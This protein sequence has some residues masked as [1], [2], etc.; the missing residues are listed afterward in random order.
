MNIKLKFGLAV[1]MLLILMSP[2]AGQQG[3]ETS[4]G[5]IQLAFDG[6]NRRAAGV[7]EISLD[8]PML[9]LGIRMLSTSES[10]AQA[11]AMLS[12]LKGVYIKSFRFDGEGKYSDSDLANVRRQLH[13]PGWAHIMSVH[14]RP[15][16]Q[17]VD[18]Y[19]M[20]DGKGVAGMAIIVACPTELRVVN[21]VGPVDPA[22]LSR[23]GG[24]FGIPQV[25]AD[26]GRKDRNRQ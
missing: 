1:P 16:R 11:R 12:R 7:N 26:A 17:D 23:L 18:V 20:S 15:D 24:H 2:L 9:Q 3:V 6:L 5:R 19:V 25:D 8:G 10:D 21:L 13:G 22:E 14:S 4:P